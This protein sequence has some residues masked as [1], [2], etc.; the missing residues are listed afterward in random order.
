[1][2]S[3]RQ[4][5]RACSLEVFYSAILANEWEKPARTRVIERLFE[6]LLRL[7]VEKYLVLASLRLGLWED[8]VRHDS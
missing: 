4:L 1:M 6:L 7:A 5:P 3:I 8:G 2:S